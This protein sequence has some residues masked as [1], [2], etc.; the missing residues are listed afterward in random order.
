LLTVGLGTFLLLVAPTFTFASISLSIFAHT[1]SIMNSLNDFASLPLP[2]PMAAIVIAKLKTS[3]LIVYL[4]PLTISG[5]MNRLCASEASAKER[6]SEEKG[7][8]ERRRQGSGYGLGW[9]LRSADL[10][11]GRLVLDGPRLAEVSLRNR[12]G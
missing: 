8:S 10:R 7:E 11:H 2:E 4:S 3:T 12:G 5:A 9:N 6:A 1:Q